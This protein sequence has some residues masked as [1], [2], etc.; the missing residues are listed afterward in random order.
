MSLIHCHLKEELDGNSESGHVDGEL[1]IGHPSVEEI[2]N[3]AIGVDDGRA[4]S[5]LGNEPHG[6]HGDLLRVPFVTREREQVI[7]LE[8]HSL[9]RLIQS[10]NISTRWQ[11]NMTRS[12]ASALHLT[13]SDGKLTKDDTRN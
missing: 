4:E 7:Y 3:F 13:R 2:D 12:L 11:C 8:D 9:G 1:A 5:R 10:D 6:P